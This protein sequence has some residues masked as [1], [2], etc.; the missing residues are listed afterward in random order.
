M[1][2]FLSQRDAPGVREP[3]AAGDKPTSSNTGFRGSLT[4]HS[5]DYTANTADATVSGLD[6]TG[7]LTINAD[8]VTVV[9]C[10]VQSLAGILVNETEDTTLEHV[11]TPTVGVSSSLR[12]TMEYLRVTGS[13]ADAFHVTS[14]GASMVTDCVI[15]HCLV[16][17]PQP[18]SEA[19]WDGLQV[20]GINGLTVENTVFDAGPW[21]FPYNACVYFEPA[22]GGNSNMVMDGCWLYGGAFGLHLGEATGTNAITNNVFGGDVEF[23]YVR[24]ENVTA[25]HYQ[26]FSGNTEEG[27]GN[28]V[29]A[30]WQ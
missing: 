22:N 5:G 30:P 23:D 16:D 13:E 18:P 6:I 24:A 12:T 8:R 21:Q 25:Q 19:H 7:Q 17:D 27:T 2:L 26:T 14:D 28:P 1:P 3:E 15:R 20:R 4:T 10:R 9:D 29:L 11:T